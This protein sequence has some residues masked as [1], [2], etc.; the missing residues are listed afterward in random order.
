MH[1]LEKKKILRAV[2]MVPSQEL[3]KK[4]N[5]INPKTIEKEKYKNKSRDHCN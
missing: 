4:K 5:K 3:T 2:I 1:S